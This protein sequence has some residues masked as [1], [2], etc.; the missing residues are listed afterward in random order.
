MKLPA[1]WARARLDEIGEVRLGRQRSPKNHTGDQM[2]PYLRAAN[3][4]WDGLKLH[5]VKEM[6]FTEQE[7]E[8]YRLQPGD[9]LLSEASGSPGEVG[10]PALWNSEIVDCCFQNTLIRVRAPQVNSK[11]LLYFLRYEALRG[12]FAEGARGVGIHHLGAA[13]LSAWDVALPPLA[14]QQRIVEVLETYLSR[15]DAAMQGLGSAGARANRL[16]LIL[17]GQAVAGVEASSSHL[18]TEEQVDLSSIEA[19]TRS[20]AKA[21]WKPVQPVPFPDYLLPNGWTMASLG[22]LAYDS[23]YGT[24]TKCDYEGTGSPV[25]RIPNVQAGQIDSADL[26]YCVDPAL[27]LSRYFVKNGDILFVRTNGSPAL[28]GRA[29]VVDKDLPYAFAS[30]LIRFRLTP[31]LVDPRWVQLVTQSP[32]WREHIERIAASS[33]GQYNLNIETLSQLPIPV[34]PMGVQERILKVFSDFSLGNLRLARAATLTVTRG[35]HLRSALFDRAFTGTLV[36]QDP[37]D[38]PAS[39]LLA[40]IQAERAAQPNRRH[41]RRTATP[42][43]TSAPRA[44]AP[45][46]QPTPVPTASEQQEL[47]L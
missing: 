12:G 42:R 40:R 20:L 34:P 14:E 29:G 31:G 11:F 10:K 9:I 3:V 23:G 7:L 21:R 5:D 13:N 41:N 25:L 17:Q 38:E 2:R 35:E 47:P 26:K 44:T 43:N 28:I 46:P 37:A 8:T 32:L 1:G 6:N 18:N 19:A 22:T 4:G 39:A 45:A 15:L 30:Y 27:D 36:P 33:A 24:S 16:S